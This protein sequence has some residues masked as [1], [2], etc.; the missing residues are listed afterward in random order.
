MTKNTKKVVCLGGGIGTVNLIKGITG[1][2]GDIT[3]A[4]SMADEGGSAGRLRRLYNIFPPGDIV[5]C[6][7]AVGSGDN[8]LISQLLT[9]RFPGD[10]Y[11]KDE[12]LAGHK[13]GSLILV[14][15]RDITGNFEKAIALFQK[16]FGISG[17]FLSATTN[18]VRISIHTKNGEEVFGEETIDLGR[19]DWKAGIEKVHLHPQ[20][21][22]ANPILLSHLDNADAIIAGP[23]DLYTTI[24]PVL[25]VPEITKK[26]QQSKAE[27]IFIVNVTNK[28]F[29]TK[30]YTILDYLSAIKKHLGF[31]PFTKVIVNNNFT[32]Q[33]P[34]LYNY[35]YVAIHTENGGLKKILSSA[36]AKLIEN[37]LIDED[38]PL[39]HSF[40]KLAKVIVQE[41]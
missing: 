30:N 4:V 32:P 6:M 12:H 5:S 25:I 40:S 24:L 23:G 2:V 21:S 11:A 28:P 31:F 13:L 9:Y 7:A 37:D 10:R 8:P 33:I 1:N 34:D 19:Y 29:E 41:L 18:P 14:A 39:Y 3:V 26:L 15:M 17:T 27:K 22:K 16:T 35:S 20:D 38:F 36:N